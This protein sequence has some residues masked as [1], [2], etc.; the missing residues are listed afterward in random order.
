MQDP[1]QDFL[2]A[3]TQLAAQLSA[4]AEGI[5][6]RNAQSAGQLQSSAVA[7]VHKTRE[8]QSATE[9]FVRQVISAIAAQAPAA[10]AKGMGNAV[11]QYQRSIEDCENKVKWACE[12]MGEQ[13]R[14]LTRAQSARVWIGMAALVLGGLAWLIGTGYVAWNKQQEIVQLGYQEQVAKVLQT[15]AVV[16]CGNNWCAKVNKNAQHYGAHGEYVQIAAP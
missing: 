6:V 3:A 15:Q 4:V 7:L 2:R 14:L 9:D 13:R 11:G 12:A 8:M 16:P 1:S 5:N 10:L